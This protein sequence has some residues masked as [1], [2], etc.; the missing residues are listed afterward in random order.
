MIFSNYD[1]GAACDLKAGT[2][3][4]LTIDEILKYNEEDLQATW[5]VFRRL[6]K[7]SWRNKAKENK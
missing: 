6:K 4:I 7:C 5:A 1:K 3:P 2:T